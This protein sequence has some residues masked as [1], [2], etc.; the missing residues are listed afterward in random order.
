[1]RLPFLSLSGMA[2][3]HLRPSS[4]WTHLTLCSLLLDRC[5]SSC[6]QD[7]LPTPP[8]V[9]RMRL[10]RPLHQRHRRSRPRHARPRLLRPPP[11]ATPRSDSATGR[12][13][14]HLVLRHRSTSSRRSTHADPTLRQRQPL[15]LRQRHC[16]RVPSPCPPSSTST[17]WRLGEST[18]FM[19]PPS[20]PPLPCLRCRRRTVGDLRILPGAPPCWRSMMLYCRIT[21]ETGCRVPARPMLSLESGSSSTS[22]P[23]TALWNGTRRARFFED[24]HNAPVLTSRKPSARLSNR[25]RSALCSPWLSHGNGLFTSLM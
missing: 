12:S 13:A 23:L 15:H 20:S 14:C 24:S 17:P 19:F 2:P 9:H 7:Y 11:S 1:M 22:S 4:F 16:P 18:V 10:R 21:L 3:P 8:P 5:T 6:L 25:R